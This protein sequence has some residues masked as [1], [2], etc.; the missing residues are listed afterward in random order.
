MTRT[1]Q[2]T[3]KSTGGVTLPLLVFIHVVTPPPFSRQGPHK[4]PST[5]ATGKTATAV[6]TGG[7]HTH[8]R[9][10][11]DFSIHTACFLRRKQRQQNNKLYQVL[12]QMRCEILPINFRESLAFRPLPEAL[13]Y[14]EAQSIRSFELDSDVVRRKKVKRVCRE[15]KVWGRLRHDSIL[16]LWGVADDFGQYPAMVYPWADNGAPTGYLERQQDLLSL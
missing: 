12:R 1:K 9:A 11:P 2:I 14:L 16:P 15:L 13:G 4:Q 7:R 10:D 5:E 3:H 6:A 8:K